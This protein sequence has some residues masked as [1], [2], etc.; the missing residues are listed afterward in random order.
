LRE[1]LTAHGGD[2]DGLDG[3]ERLD[4]PVNPDSP[5]S[6]DSVDRRDGGRQ[7][8]RA[9]DV[10]F[11]ETC[12]RGAIAAGDPE[13]IGASALLFLIRLYQLT[14][15]EDLGDS[16]GNAL[17]AALAR[18][19]HGSTVIDR[20]SWL[21]LLVE[22]RTLSDDDRVSAAIELLIDQL[23]DAWVSSR[24]EDAATALDACLLAAGLPEH[25]ALASDAIDGMER[26]IAATYRPGAGMGAFADQVRTASALLTA[27][28]LSGRLPYPM[29]AEELMQIAGRAGHRAQGPQ[30]AQAAQGVQD[31]QGDFTDCCE[32]ARV[33]CRLA[34]LH[35][36]ADYRR[37]AVVTPGA[38]YRRDAAEMLAAQADEA[39]RQGAA[40]AIYGVA[41]LE[42]ESAGST[43]QEPAILNSVP[44][45]ETP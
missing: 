14:G 37:A 32:A 31:V 8:A 33:F 5:D 4:R 13:S 34:A 21:G 18:P 23:R 22:A 15:R 44:A 7:S 28:A 40:G 41:L 11:V 45:P 30:G 36:Q 16:V 6:P 25:R 3:L 10:A 27:Y 1:H 17:A 19:E 35:D 43:S 39:R 26:V 29:L 20:A 2:D 12:V 42:L 38:D 24:V 9:D